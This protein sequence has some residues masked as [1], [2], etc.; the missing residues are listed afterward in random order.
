MINRNRKSYISYT[1]SETKPIECSV[2]GKADHMVTINHFGRR[3]VQYFSCKMFVDMTPKQ[4]FKLLFDKGFCYQCLSPGATVEHGKHKTALCYNKFVCKHKAHF[5]Y[6]RKKHV[7]LCEDH[8]NDTE[9]SGLLEKYKKENI[10]SIKTPLADFTKQIKLSFHCNKTSHACKSNMDEQFDG[11]EVMDSSVYILQT[12]QI[13]DRKFN[14]FFDGGCSELVCRK[15]GISELQKLGKA[16]QLVPGPV[17]L[18]G[19]GNLKVESPHGIYKLICLYV[20]G[21]RPLC[22]VFV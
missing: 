9:N 15:E 13:K 14:I 19:V 12:I 11:S 18:G 17:A 5:K 20:L 2:C 21:S 3:V 7:L 1:S 10:D 4:R 8:K 22:K 6:P 16:S